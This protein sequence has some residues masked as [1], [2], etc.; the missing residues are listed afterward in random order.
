MI[1]LALILVDALV[2]AVLVKLGG[3]FWPRAI[4]I[5]VTLAFNFVV[6]HSLDSYRGY[7]A[8]GIPADSVFVSC[9]V[10]EPDKK[11][12]TEGRVYFWLV[13]KRH[14]GFLEYR[15]EDI[16]PRAYVAPYERDLHEACEGAKQQSK[17]G[18]PV[19]LRR[20][21]GQ[22]GRRSSANNQGGSSGNARRSGSQYR[23]YPLPPYS[24]PRKDAP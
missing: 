2:L 12:H 16:E 10:I 3:R 18:Q 22:Q 4:A 24:P 13:E 6:W 21:A 23:P 11:A 7:P 9:I 19:G 15:P 14:A 20:V 5:V 8:E 17:G 1:V